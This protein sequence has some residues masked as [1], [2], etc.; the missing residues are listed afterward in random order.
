M[1]TALVARPELDRQA[2]AIERALLG[3]SLPVRVNGGE[4]DGE[5]VRFHVVPV[6]GTAPERVCRA[7]SAVAERMGVAEVRIVP[8]GRALALDVPL[9]HGGEPRLLPLLAALGTLPRW[10]TLVGMAEGGAPLLMPL[11]GPATDTV[12]ALGPAG[13]GKSELLRALT[14]SLALTTP[15]ACLQLVGIDIGGREL[16]VLESLP[17]LAGELATTPR[18]AQALLAS[19]AA[20]AEGGR[21]GLVPDRARVLIVDDDRWLMGAEAGQLPLLRRLVEVGPAAGIHVMAASRQ[22][23]PAWL[24]RR[25]GVVVAQALHYSGGASSAA[26]GRF[27]LRSHRDVARVRAAFLTAGDL[28]EVARL[29][30]AGWAPGEELPLTGASA[31]QTGWAA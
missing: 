17:H 25:P 19:L 29:V 12:V 20:E 13:S 7:A 23:R 30:L 28:N 31:D 21:E 5:W 1:A 16:T 11:R 26:P 6:R 8:A 27:L 22:P 3:L 4:I 15:A 24:T 9:P 10:T 14:L 18:Q 2:D